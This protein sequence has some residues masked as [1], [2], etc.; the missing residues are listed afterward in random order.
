MQQ[1]HEMNDTSQII[2]MIW[3]ILNVQFY[4][5]TGVKA[6]YYKV[7]SDYVIVC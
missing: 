6:Y 1:T 5:Q 7:F 2:I 3:L 4:I